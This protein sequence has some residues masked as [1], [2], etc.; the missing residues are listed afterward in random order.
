MICEIR[1]KKNLQQLGNHKLELV[2][3]GKITAYYLRDPSQGRI[4]STLIVFTP[5]G[6]ALMGDLTPER[7]G[8]IS[9]FGYGVD[10]FAGH[11]SSGY[12]CEKFLEKK[13]IREDAKLE[14]R[15]RDRWADS[16]ELNEDQISA[17]ASLADDVDDHG[18]EWLY[19]SLTE[20]IPHFSG[21]SVPG[22][23]YDGREANW[24]CAIQRRFSELYVPAEAAART[25][26]WRKL[27]NNIRRCAGFFGLPARRGC[28]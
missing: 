28:K 17:I 13:W 21:E 20:I 10:W 25:Q 19:E 26:L 12:L 23:G 11:K 2:Q 5:E 1:I 24:L 14:L 3:E 6:I 15:D 16:Y 22:F 9:C 7:S 4:M 27:L 8:S 18:V